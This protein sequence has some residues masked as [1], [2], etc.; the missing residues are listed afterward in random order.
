MP[1]QASTVTLLKLVSAGPSRLSAPGT[2]AADE[3]QYPATIARRPAT[4]EVMK[5]LIV[6]LPVGGPSRLSVMPF[7]PRCV[8]RVPIASSRGSIGHN[9]TPDP[10]C[11]LL[12]R[13]FERAHQR[14]E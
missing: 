10:S 2:S 4:K 8:I 5:R 7:S 9:V 11:A 12:R 3:T 14:Q 6:N 13:R 1:A